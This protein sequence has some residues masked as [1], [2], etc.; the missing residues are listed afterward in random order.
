MECMKINQVYWDPE[1]GMLVVEFSDIKINI[2]L[3]PAITHKWFNWKKVSSI[4]INDDNPGR[5]H[6]T[7]KPPIRDINKFIKDVIKN[8]LP[9]YYNTDNK[10][11]KWINKQKKNL[12]H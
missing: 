8:W 5:K 9:E 1:I 3:R 7:G 2:F 6:G 12:D 11:M 4:H 10:S